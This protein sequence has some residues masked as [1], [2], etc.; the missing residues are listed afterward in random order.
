MIG[1][2]RWLLLLVQGGQVVDLAQQPRE[3]RAQ[4]AGTI[5]AQIQ[6]L[7]T[8]HANLMVEAGEVDLPATADERNG[9]ADGARDAF[10][11]T[12]CA[13]AA[14]SFLWPAKVPG[15]RGHSP[16]MTEPD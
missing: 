10:K 4:F 2:P 16:I 12:A 6:R 1:P 9:D 11:L 8:Q 5:P 15:G 14:V 3:F 13:N 7:G